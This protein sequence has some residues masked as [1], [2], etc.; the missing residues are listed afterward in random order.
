[1]QKKSFVIVALL[2]T[3]FIHA[4]LTPEILF[5]KFNETGTKI[6][7]HASSV[8]STTDTAD[9]VGALT[10]TPGSIC[11]G[12]LNGVELTSSTNYV[13][14]NW[15]TSLNGDFTISFRTSNIT[16]SITLFYMFGDVNTGLRLFTNGV[17]GS[18]NWILRGNGITDLNINGAAVIA[19][20]MT[21]ITYDNATLE[22]KGY[23]NGILN[24][25]VIQAAPI[26]IVSIDNFKVGGYGT[27]TGLNLGGKMEEFR[28]YSRTLTP[29]EIME[30]YNGPLPDLLPSSQLICS[31]NASISIQPNYSVDTYL[32]STGATNDS[33]QVSNTGSYTLTAIKECKSITD[34]VFVTEGFSYYSTQVT[35]CSSSLPYISVFGDTFS[36]GGIYQT[37]GTNAIGCDSILTLDLTVSHVDTNIVVSGSENQTLTAPLNSDA[38]QWIDCST[39]TPIAGETSHTFTATQNGSYAVIVTQNNCSNT[40]QCFSVYSLSLDESNNKL[41]HIYP[42]PST[43]IFNIQI[44]AHFTGNAVLEIHSITGQKLSSNNVHS[45]SNFEFELNQPSGMYILTLKDTNGNKATKQIIKK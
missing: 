24:N 4:Q 17:A 44:P 13:N 16:P 7:N 30:L 11:A 21:T 32:W 6:T 2:F 43:G 15:P 29:T 3:Q 33:I 34:T 1:M 37:I 20:T 10:Q 5:Y 12:A 23:V 42:N 39:N 28:L 22:L 27:N 36:N 31:E 19:P 35:I 25:T 45:I 40:S 18:N 26:N 41:L 9:I 8:T 14:S 38:Y